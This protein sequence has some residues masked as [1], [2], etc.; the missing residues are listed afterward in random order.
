MPDSAT[1]LFHPLIDRLAH[2]FGKTPG[3]LLKAAIQ[4][5]LIWAM[6]WVASWFL[7]VIA[8]RIVAAVDDGDDTTM[9]AAEKRGQTIAQL[10]RS[11]GRV[12]I[13]VTVLMLTLNLFVDIGPILAGFGILSLAISFGSQSLV[14]DF[15]SGFFILL[16]NQF[17]VGDVVEVA[18]KSGVVER[19]TM[20]VVILRDLQGVMH[21][22]PNGAITLVS[23]MTRG[24]SRAVVDVGISYQADLNRVLD[25]FKDEVLQLN[26]DPAW[27]NR[28][29]GL[30]EI[31]GVEN[32]G[33]S[34]IVVRTLIRSLPGEQ[35]GLA[36]EFRRRIKNR[37]DAE[38]IEIPYPQRVVHLKTEDPASSAKTEAPVSPAPPT[39][40]SPPPLTPPP[41]P[42]RPA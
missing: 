34:S 41:T 12:V 33:D 3:D 32:L 27:H 37:L 4:M 19:M 26:R 40:P 16:E 11:V 22:I 8:K 42:A 2:L 15:I 9:T 14:K 38:G 17:V 28:F 30:P 36:R 35:W 25:V 39:P 1:V 18:G 13:I 7:N 21:V 24:W 5:V 10:L 6:G 20:R 31:T 23:N 29:D